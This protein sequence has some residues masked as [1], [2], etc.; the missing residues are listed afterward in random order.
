MELELDFHPDC[1]PVLS[2][3]EHLRLIVTN[4]VTNASQAMGESGG[5]LKIRLEAAQLDWN[6]CEALRLAQP[7]LFVCLTISDQGV[8]IA[9]EIRKRIFEPYFTTREQH[10]GTGLGL[11]IV[12]V[13]RKITVGIVCKCSR[14][15]STS[16][17]ICRLSG[18][19]GPIGKQFRRCA[20]GGTNP[21]ARGRRRKTAGNEPIGSVY[22]GYQVQAFTDS[23]QAFDFFLTDPWSADVAILDLRM[24]KLN[25]LELAERLLGVRPNLPIILCTGFP[26]EIE[27]EQIQ[28][29]G[30]AEFLAKP[31][32]PANLALCVDKILKQPHAV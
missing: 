16:V 28:T 13:V 20:P 2:D 25:G 6:D 29:L 10:G 5:L 30:I 9:P 11:A 24:P 17:S 27:R 1:P 12:Q 26:D 3:A 32:T 22:L 18:F 8:G 31:V 4:L 14:S 7:G 21:V 15:G 23:E 19:P